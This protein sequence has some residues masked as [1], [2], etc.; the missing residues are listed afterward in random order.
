M[1]PGP[2][3]ARLLKN[4]QLVAQGV[5]AIPIHMPGTTFS[6][7]LKAL[8]EILV[9]LE[10][11]IRRRRET[12]ANDALSRI[13]AARTPGG[14]G[15]TDEQARL[16]LHHIVV[17]GYIIFAEF[18]AAIIELHRNPEICRGLHTEVSRTSPA[19]LLTMEQMMEMPLMMRVVMEVKRLCPIL[20]AIFGKA[21]QSFDPDRFSRERSEHKKHE[22][23][24]VPHGLGPAIGH[25]CPGTDYS[26]CFMFAFLTLLLREHSWELPEQDLDYVWS[27][28]SPEP[29]CGLNVRFRRN[30]G[31]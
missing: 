19:G 4:Y 21:R 14:V 29:R 5:S 26:T 10:D 2:E 16:E 23:A 9:I 6:R 28:T 31:S 20:P 30:S 15:I 3:L 24:Y 8:K 12:P 13:L 18:A 17:A 27:M 7:A 25:K 1:E 22:H 11:T